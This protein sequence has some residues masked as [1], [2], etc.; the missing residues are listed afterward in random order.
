[1]PIRICQIRTETLRQGGNAQRMRVTQLAV[2]DVNQPDQT[3]Q[4]RMRVTQIA[5]EFPFTL[6]T[7]PGPPPPPSPTQGDTPP[8]ECSPPP[9]SECVTTPAVQV[10][11]ESC[12]QLGS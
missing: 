11:D 2:E 9:T 3:S 7:P 6:T 5:I 10:T 1:M 4:Q 12:E 8:A